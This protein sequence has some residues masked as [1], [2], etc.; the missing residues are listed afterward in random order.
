MLDSSKN[1]KINIERKNIKNLYVRIKSYNDI[2]VS[3]PMRMPLIEIY[4]FLESKKLW[5]AKQNEKFI[6]A[7]EK[8]HPRKLYNHDEI[9]YIYG[10]AYILKLIP[11]T[12]RPKIRLT[13]D[14]IFFYIDPLADIIKKT[15]LFE[16]WYSKC[17]H[18]T[19]LDLVRKWEIKMNVSVKHVQIR[20]MKTR[21]GSCSPGLKSIRINFE[22]A[23]RSVE[24]I[25][26]IVVHELVHLL[27]PSHNKRFV[28]FMDTFLPNWRIRKRELNNEPLIF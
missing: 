13:N 7:D 14:C 15:V 17:L 5:I 28:L 1:I 3:A 12:G 16:R 26:Y 21:W 25:E 20:K 8:S 19:V 4:N 24:C 23:K 22:L 6:H 2:K 10:K 18:L 27:E 11:H 9:H